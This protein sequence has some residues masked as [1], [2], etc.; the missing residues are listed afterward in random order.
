MPPSHWA[1]DEK[2]ELKQETETK[3]VPPPPL[4]GNKELLGAWTNG[5]PLSYWM[6]PNNSN[7]GP[8]ATACQ[9]II[10]TS[11]VKSEHPSPTDRPWWLVGGE[12]NLGDRLTKDK[13]KILKKKI[14]RGPENQTLDI[15]TD[16]VR[17]PG[18]QGGEAQSSQISLRLLGPSYNANNPSA[19]TCLKWRRRPVG[20]GAC[21]AIFHGALGAKKNLSSEMPSAIFIYLSAPQPPP[22][23]CQPGPAEPPSPSGHTSLLLTCVTTCPSFA[24]QRSLPEPL[25]AGLHRSMTTFLLVC[26]G[27]PTCA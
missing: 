24:L 18:T 16:K 5:Y 23:V 1:F 21:R 17:N 20:P 2:L 10:K 14:L 22:P 13:P 7:N 11:K 3:G 9:I 25:Q 8:E 15:H 12:S 6:S 4:T 27:T 19:Q 26:Q